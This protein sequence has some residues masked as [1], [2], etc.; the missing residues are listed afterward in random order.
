MF[1]GSFFSLQKNEH[2]KFTGILR[3]LYNKFFKLFD[4]MFIFCNEYVTALDKSR[5][6]APQ[7]TS[8]L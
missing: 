4:Y 2:M 8:R 3:T 7:E 5:R 1:F 6:V